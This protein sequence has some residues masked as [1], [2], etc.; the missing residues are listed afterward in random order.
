MSTKFQSVYML[1]PPLTCTAD[2]MHIIFNLLGHVVVD[3]VL[4][5]LKVQALAGHVCGNQHI[6]LACRGGCSTGL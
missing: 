4:D 1:P 6:L 3:D 2:A 5:A